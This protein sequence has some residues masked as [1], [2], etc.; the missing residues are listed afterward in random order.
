MIDETPLTPPL[1]Y[2]AANP[3]GKLSVV[4]TKPCTT[5][6][7]LALAYTPGVAEPC[8]A[9]R[10][11][12]ADAYRFT[13]KGNSVAVISNGTAVLGLG[14]LGALASKPVMEGKSVLFKRF[15]DIDSVDIEVDATEPGH[16]VD[17]VSAI[18]P[19]FGG[20]NLEDIKA[21]ECF[22]I[23][24]R[25]KER[26]E[27]PVFHDDQHGTA[28][29]IASGL[30]NA[31]KIAEKS[32][33]EVRIVVSGAGSAS[34]AAI[35][36]LR[37][38]G[39]RREQV[40]VLDTKGVIHTGRDLSNDPYKAEV[41]TYL[42]FRTLAQALEGAD[43]FIGVSAP[44]VVTPQMLNT[45]A[46]HPI[47]FALAN[48]DPEIP[49]AVAR[50]SRPDVIVAT[51]RS[52]SPNQVNNVLAFPFLFRAAL[53]VRATQVNFAMMAAAA[54]AIASLAPQDEPDA[55][56]PSAF[57]PRLLETVSLAV[58]KAARQTGVARRDLHSGDYRKELQIRRAKLDELFG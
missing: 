24:N 14:N 43:V 18:S 25:L 46:S 20:I 19:T 54:K 34:L 56:I 55:I 49:H 41:A 15:A 3:A 35:K 39:V 52:D 38:L 51:G 10:N 13:G 8:L 5:P 27:I 12:P 16:F 36:F 30:I 31:L 53:D 57:D 26:L 23:E 9:I 11:N 6:Q 22:E 17:V 47:V 32:I 42:P 29:V 1:E 33:R 40:V 58:A 21:P 44:G 37:Y 4:P 48:P 2:H 50:A 7:E 28:V 45:M